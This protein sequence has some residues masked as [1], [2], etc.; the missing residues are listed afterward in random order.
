MK[1]ALFSC[2]GLGDGLL[3]LIIAHNLQRAGDITTTFHPFLQGM[4]PWFPDLFLAPF[5]EPH[6]LAEFDRYI[7]VYEKSSWMHSI[8]NHCKHYYPEK[9]FILNPIATPNKDYPY[10]EVGKFDGRKT[11]AYN[12]VRFCEETLGVKEGIKSN[13]ITFPKEITP[14]K[15]PQRVI[16]HPTSSRPGK[17]WPQKKFLKLAEELKNS[18]FEPVFLLTKEEKASWPNTPFAAPEF[19][20]LSAAAAFVAESGSMI[21][22]DSGIGHLAS[23]LGLPTVTLCRSKMNARFWRPDF[24]PNLVLTP[25]DWLPNLKGLRLRDK[26]WKE[27]I[28]VSSVLKAHESLLT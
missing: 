15:Y 13:G 4:Q 19:A 20:S 26:Y 9:T 6:Q 18:G 8:L 21:G 11:F 3:A 14:H 12:L 1:N 5:P 2:Q 17:N 10:W 22:N 27:T 24:A 7:L 28:S 16:L 25:P 23:S